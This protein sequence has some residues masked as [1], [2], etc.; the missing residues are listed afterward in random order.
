[1]ILFDLNDTANIPAFPGFDKA[2]EFLR[3]CP[4]DQPDGTVEIDGKNVYAIIQ[5]YETRKEKN[6]P[7]FEAHHNYIDIQFLLS[8]SELMGWAPADAMDVNEPYSEEK[9]ILFG[10]VPEESRA[11][12]FFQAGQ[13]MVLFPSD[14]HAPGLSKGAPQPVRKVV[15]KIRQVAD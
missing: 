9:D 7:R 6:E 4:A 8:G 10:T 15:V 13:A 1:M 2:V 3:S 12:T 11:F 14:A 5:T